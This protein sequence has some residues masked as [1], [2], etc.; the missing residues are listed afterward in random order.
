MTLRGEGEFRLRHGGHG[1]HAAG[2]ACGGAGAGAA[3]WPAGVAAR[4]TG[5]A[6]SGVMAR[7]AISRSNAAVVRVDSGRRDRSQIASPKL[8]FVPKFCNFRE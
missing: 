1:G 8:R 5:V 4:A 2:G 3:R 7:A 6:V